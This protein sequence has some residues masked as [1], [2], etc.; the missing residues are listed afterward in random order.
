MNKENI[1]VSSA[2]DRPLVRRWAVLAGLALAVVLLALSAASARAA[3]P[4]GISDFDGEVT[5]DAGGTPFTQAGGHP[6]AATTWIDFNSAFD[7]DFG[8][9]MPAED[10]KDLHVSLPPG[11]IGNV[12]G[13]PQCTQQDFYGKG[14]GPECNSDAIVGRAGI[15]TLGTSINFAVFNLVPPPGVPAMFGFQALVQPVFV[16]ASLRSGGDYGVDV[17]IPDISQ[18]L[19]LT[20]TSLTLWG[21]PA[22]PRHDDQRCIADSGC[23]KPSSAPRSPLLT[24]PTSCSAPGV[25]LETKL[26]ADSWVH[27]EIVERA[28]FSSHLP[29]A[30][31]A[32][33]GDRGAQQGTAGCER[34]PFDAKI[35]AQGDSRAAGGPTGLDVDLTV[36]Q[37]G[38]LNADGVAPAHVKRVEMTLPEG[39]TVNPSAAD[40]LAG[41][42]A[43]QIDLKGTGDPSCPAGSKLGT[44]AI[45]TPVLADPLEG[46]VYLGAQGDN[47]FGTLLSMYIVA[48]GPGLIVKLPGRIDADPVTGRLTTTFDNQPQLPFSKLS[49]RLKSGARAPL[50]NPKACGTYNLHSVLTPW[51]GNA[52]VTI[53]QPMV[54]D[55]G[56]GQA[57][58]FT[59]AMNAG[60]DNPQAGG[61]PS[62]ILDL[63]RPDG[64]QDIGSFDLTM[65]G[66]VLGRIAGVPQCPD[67]K[68]AAGACDAASRIGH[69]TVASGAGPAPLAIPQPGKAATAVYLAGPYKGAPFSIS[70]VVP[71][72]AGPFDL[73]TVVVRAGLYIDP[74]DAH[75]TVKTDPLPTI[76]QGILLNVQKINVTL[77]RAGF[78]VNPTS[79]D[80][81][82]ITG[83]VASAQGAVAAVSSRFQVGSC[84]KLGL[85]PEL[86]LSLSGKGQTR[87]GGHPAVSAVLTQKPGQSNLKKVR[88]A[89]PLSLA[90]DPDNAESDGLCSFVEGSK[91]DPKCPASSL[92]G[93][94]T[95]VSPIL[96]EPMTG[97]VYFVKNERKDPKSGRS[98]KTTPK[99]VIPLVGENGVKLTLTG[100]STVTDDQLVTTFD[101]IPDASVS[102]F[103]MDITGGKKGI[104]VVSAADICKST[105]IADQQVDGQNGKSADAD[106]YIQTPSCP[107]KVL[108]K[109][110]GKSSVALKV[111]GLSAG[112]VTVTGK[113]IKKTTKTITKS[114]VA[115]ITAKRTKGKPGKVTVSFD[116]TGPAKARKTS[117]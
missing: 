83:Q 116:P 81:T 18:G 91:P 30:W 66:G 90:L 48:K 73:G 100:A 33:P 94:A 37:E 5:A 61:S 55:H 22:D 36:D 32:A 69:T 42:S 31:P 80:P 117:K 14:A 98:I 95:A 44:V 38:L 12:Q 59:P 16:T 86:T 79:C 111:G 101:N 99:L 97:P 1:M 3:L 8:L 93:K 84:A 24:L 76:L 41:C 15:K 62:F 104:L 110:V 72:Q 92:V 2:V 21:V 53:D 13:V 50:A 54:I 23:N 34:V 103:K 52:P 115:T 49:L 63:S 88:V 74:I 82:Q 17:D 70:T 107:L 4:F 105:Q 11:F 106:V 65:P 75:V 58:R 6:F 112:K 26:S 45:D 67:A 71:A 29:P 109:K 35:A 20:G 39:M 40:G 108:S 113:G 19:A 47:P 56:C 57:G 102:S 28:S 43:A 96:N 51:S 60:V 78:M 85:K 114:T 64:Q 9:S 10:I 68:A 89:L 77:D 25:G 87:D 27:P 7:P 46:T